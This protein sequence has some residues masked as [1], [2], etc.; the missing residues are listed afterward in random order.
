MYRPDE[1]HAGP[2]RERSRR[3]G[4]QT[5][6]ADDGNVVPAEVTQA[7]RFIVTHR[8]DGIADIGMLQ[9]RSDRGF[10]VGYRPAG[11]RL[12][13]ASRIAPIASV[14]STMVGGLASQDRAQQR[15]D[16]I[17]IFVRATHPRRDNLPSSPGNQQGSSIL[18]SS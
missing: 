18:L 13:T 4:Q 6:V 17:E 3:W 2:F 15:P 8:D 14:S 10:K 5:R 12:A 16:P 9:F 1:Q 11:E 7:C